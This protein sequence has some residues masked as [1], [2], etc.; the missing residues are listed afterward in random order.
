M[1][2]LVTNANA[3]SLYAHDGTYLGELNNNRTDPNSVSNPYGQYGNKN[4]P[5]SINNPYGRYGNN[6]SEEGVN[7][8]YANQYPTTPP[9]GYSRDQ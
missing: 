4:S 1:M 5:N 8:P 7:N 2:I 6:Y 9:M 3:V